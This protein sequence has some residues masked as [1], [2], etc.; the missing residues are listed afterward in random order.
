MADFGMKRIVCM[1]LSLLCMLSCK[2]E[3]FDIIIAGGGTSGCT[4]GIQAASMGSKTL[5]VEP[6][7]WLGGMLTSAGVSATDGC[8][9]LPSGLWGEFQRRL[10]E[11]YGGMEALKTGWVSNIQ[12]EPSVGNMIFNQMCSE[13]ELLSVWKESS[14]TDIRQ[15]KDGS[16]KV[17]VECKV[18]DGQTTVRRVRARVVIDA[19][20]LGDIAACCGVGYD[21]GMESRDITGERIAPLQSNGIIQDLTYVAILKDYG[22]DVSIERA[23]GYDSSMYACCCANPLC[24]NP[25]EPERIWPADMMISYGKL[26]GEKYMINWPIE[27]NDFYLNIIE[28]DPEQ[29]EKEL[30]KARDFTMGFIYFI[31]HQL[32]YNTLGLAD[33]EFPTEDRLPFIPYHRESR[34]IHGKVRFT[35]NHIERPYDYT[36]FRTGIAVGD[37]PVDHHH[38]RYTAEEELPDLHFFPIPSFTVPVGVMIPQGVEGLIVA[39][40]SI[41]VSNIANGTTRL[42][43]VVMQIG[44]AAGALA[45]EAAVQGILPSEVPVRQVQ[46]DLLDAGCYIQPFIDAKPG[47]PLFPA[48]QR[49]GSTGILRG[50]GKQ[51][52][53]TNVTDLH[54][55]ELVSRDELR[56]LFDFYG[57][58]YPDLSGGPALQAEELVEILKGF[59]GFINGVDWAVALRDAGLDADSAINGQPLT[60]A[61]YAV[62]IDCLLDPFNTF[63]VDL[64]GK[65][66]L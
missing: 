50:E 33:D 7:P 43:P 27:G 60:R 40:K 45:A 36:L 65:L 47:S 53:W 25:K 42:Q 19:T 4:A 66:I 48:L 58:T 20:E 23:V 12:F 37:Y 1:L 39:E 11:H 35:L 64:Q 63:D 52:Q 44:Q 10:S 8:Y 57:I 16:W 22:H 32:G 30:Q 21:I 59:P 9:N 61:A 51:I 24:I 26:P 2:Y 28:M 55:D 38:K 41:S 5:I 54:A 49:I 62:I 56:Y 18:A 14:I 6:L 34:R 3:Q 17:K 15:L 29:R 31:Q 46:R 13:Q